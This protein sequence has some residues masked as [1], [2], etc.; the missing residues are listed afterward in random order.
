MGKSQ[1]YPYAFR[2]RVGQL[3]RCA[4][5][6]L[7]KPELRRNLEGGP[8]PREQGD[9]AHPIEAE[10]P[11]RVPL[12][13]PS[14]AIP[15]SPVEHQPVGLDDP[16]LLPVSTDGVVA[17]LNGGPPLDRTPQGIEHTLEA[18]LDRSGNG[19]LATWSHAGQ[20]ER[21]LA[22]G[23][24]GRRAQRRGTQGQHPLRRPAE[25]GQ[26]VQA[27]RDSRELIGPGRA[28][29][30]FSD[31]LEIGEIEIS[32]AEPI[33]FDFLVGVVGLDPGPIGFDH[34]SESTKLALIPLELAAHRLA[35]PVAATHPVPLVVLDLA[36][37]LF[38]SHRVTAIQEKREQV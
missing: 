38:T 8:L 27:Q 3:P 33:G 9:R 14:H 23:G 34:D 16:L 22:E 15:V 18:G 12:P 26:L 35:S 37:D 2:R 17:A 1:S 32:R 21:E 11:D 25:N 20:V 24:G 13:G 7:G 19:S 36:Q 5:E 28:G 10:D 29:A 4:V 6:I 31:E 30:E